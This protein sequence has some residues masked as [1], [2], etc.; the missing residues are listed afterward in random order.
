MALLHSFW[1]EE[2]ARAFG[3]AAATRALAV[4]TVAQGLEL[5]RVAAND[6]LVTDYNRVAMEARLP[7]GGRAGRG[8]DHGQRGRVC[9]AMQPR[10]LCLVALTAI[11]TAGAPPPPANSG[12]VRLTWTPTTPRAGSLVVLAVHPDGAADSVSAIRG[13]LAGESLHFERVADG[14]RALGAV[15]LGASFF[16][17]WW[18]SSIPASYCGKRATSSPARWASAKTT[19]APGEKFEA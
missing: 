13:E 8:G 15:P 14:F 17:E 3:A 19:F 9:C 6:A 10:F 18:R 1:W 5:K 16:C 11:L 4:G 12:T 2:G 7:G